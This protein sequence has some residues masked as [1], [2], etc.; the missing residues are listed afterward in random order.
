MI[1]EA[2]ESLANLDMKH[3][4]NGFKKKIFLDAVLMSY[5][6][7]QQWIKRYGE[8]ADTMV[9][10]TED[11]EEMARLKHIREICIN[12]SNNA[13][14]NFHEALQLTYFIHLLIH[15]ESNG[16]S[17][18]FGRIDQYLIHYYEKD[19]N[20]ERISYDQALDLIHHFYIKVSRLN[21]VRPWP[22]TR[23]KSGA[24]MF[25]TL[26]LGGVTK[27]GADASNELTY[28]FLEAL[29]E[30]RLPQPTP[31]GPGKS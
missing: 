19:N 3:D 9:S 8:L 29:K 18:S 1:K 20:E 26:T 21:K 11:A 10:E 15:I 12:L 25:I 4:V 13:P 23:L 24:P 27:N 22:E 17:I 14:Q 28:L 6:A 31:T 30:T 16:H 7:V 2:K 5:E